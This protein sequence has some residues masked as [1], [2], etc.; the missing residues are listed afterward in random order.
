MEKVKKFKSLEVD[1]ANEA[2][3]QVETGLMSGFLGAWSDEFLG[4][5]EVL[6]FEKIA[7]DFFGFK[8]S[9]SVNSWTSGLQLMVAAI[10]ADDYDAEVIVTPWTMSAT[11]MA[12]VTNGLKPVFVDIEKDSFMPSP[13][14]IKSAVT[15]KTCAILMAD[16][17]GEDNGIGVRSAVGMHLPHNIPVE[18]EAAFLLET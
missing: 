10:G 5:S 15:D 12:I 9:I 2:K 6:K 7:A 4:G 11:V 14:S 18:I 3:K 1:D 17:F 13:E 16:I 8:Y